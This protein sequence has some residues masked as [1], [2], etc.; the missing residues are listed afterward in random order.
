[1]ADGEGNFEPL[2]PVFVSG[3]SPV[4]LQPFESVFVVV[5]DSLD[6]DVCTQAFQKVKVKE[7]RI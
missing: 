3:T 2:T 5:K 6:Q 1:M 4:V 7:N